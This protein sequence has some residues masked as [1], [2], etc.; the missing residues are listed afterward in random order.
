MAPEPPDMFD[1]VA[2]ALKNLGLS[3]EQLNSIKLSQKHRDRPM[4]ERLRFSIMSIKAARRGV[5]DRLERFQATL[6]PAVKASS[7]L[8]HARCGTARCDRIAANR[9]YAGSCLLRCGRGVRVDQPLLT[10]QRFSA[11]VCHLLVGLMSV[12]H[13]AEALADLVFERGKFCHSAT[14]P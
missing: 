13:A 9:R 8:H 11:I 10:P 3:E 2:T 14:L 7:R 4:D 5:R 12:D 1:S 6:D